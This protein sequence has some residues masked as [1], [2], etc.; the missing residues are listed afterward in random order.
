MQKAFNNIKKSFSQASNKLMQFKAI[1][2]LY[3]SIFIVTIVIFWSKIV[4]L[5]K[6]KQDAENEQK[7]LSQNNKDYLAAKRISSDGYF[8]NG[9]GQKTKY[10]ITQA[11]ENAESL[12]AIMNTYKGANWY[13]ITISFFGFGAIAR[14]KSILN[15]N[16]PAN[17]RRYVAGVYKDVYTDYRS[18]QTDVRTNLTGFAGSNFWTEDLTKYFQF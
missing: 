4:S 18:L 11:R 8:Y 7:Q 9:L 10:N 3:L 5:F 14:I 1:N 16:Y 13:A 12:A 17:Y 15:K 6:P 2:L